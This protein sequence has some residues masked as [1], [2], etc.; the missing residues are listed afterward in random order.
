VCCAHCGLAI[1]S[2]RPSVAEIM[3]YYPRN[4][5]TRLVRNSSLK[6]RVKSQVMAAIGGYSAPNSRVIRLERMLLG[7]IDRALKLHIA[8]L[9]PHV[10]GGKLLDVGCGNGSL[11]GWAGQFGWEA[12]G[13]DVD[14]KALDLARQ[15]G[16]RVTLGTVQDANYPSGYFD[17][18][19]LMQVLEHCFSPSKVLLECHRIL[20]DSGLLIVCVPNFDSLDRR[21]FGGS[22]AALQC[23]MHL[24]H[25]TPATLREMLEKCGFRIERIY[26]KTWFTGMHRISWRN[27]SHSLQVQRW[28]KRWACLV[29]LRT[30]LCVKLLKALVGTQPETMG[31]FMTVYA[32]KSSVANRSI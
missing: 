10:P 25:F 3:L 20:K 11:L 29:E 27:L 21:L 7:M 23:P 4:Y 26:Y 17:T 24:F 18:I 32:R 22:L 15:G 9:V 30:Q 6:S 16:H 5:Y 19:T 28:Y 13:V 1:T 2:P 31:E 14:E 12:Y 8:P